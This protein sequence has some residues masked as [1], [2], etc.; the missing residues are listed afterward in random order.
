MSFE[1]FI[2]ARYLRAKR[3]QA[4]I[5]VIT[6]IS[7]LGIAAGVFSLIVA[8]AINNGFRQDLQERLLGSSSH[9]NL[10]RTDK[11][12]IFEWRE[13]EERLAKQSH[14][15]AS[16]PVIYE[17]VLASRGARAQ[18]IVLKGVIPEQEQRVSDL[19]QNTHEGSIAPLE[20][21]KS[22]DQP[23]PPILLGKDLADAI[24]AKVGEVML[25][26]SPQGELTPFGIVPKY[27][28]FRVAGIFRSGF[29]D[30]DNNWAFTSLTAAQRLFGEGDIAM[31][32]EFKLDDLYRAPQVGNELAKTAGPGQMTSRL[33]DV[34]SR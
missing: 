3:R 22:A 1:L 12:G 15:I 23:Y 26:T 10:M 13:L 25:V 5:G 4:V 11:A 14:V 31:A 32:I 18:G 6:A 19:L 16:A 24:G 33:L 34:P 8:L 27:V 7:V 9:V 17:T 29:Y 2:A 21:P 28:R 20:D 30:Y